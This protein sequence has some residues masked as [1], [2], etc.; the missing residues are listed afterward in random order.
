MLVF[1]EYSAQTLTLSYV[2][3]G[4][5]LWVGDGRGQ[6]TEWAGVGDA[7]VGSVPVV[8]LFELAQGMA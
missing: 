1:V 4:D 8:E 2:Q 3:A 7:L 6:W 5:L